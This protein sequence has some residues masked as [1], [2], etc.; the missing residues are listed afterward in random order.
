MKATPPATYIRP[1]SIASSTSP[2]ATPTSSTTRFTTGSDPRLAPTARRRALP[3][4]RAATAGGPAGL[5]CG[6]GPGGRAVPGL[7]GPGCGVVTD[8]RSG[9]FRLGVRCASDCEEDVL[10]G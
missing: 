10:G 7:G 6:G 5:P 8:I 4:G 2:I 3:T 9:L 1:R